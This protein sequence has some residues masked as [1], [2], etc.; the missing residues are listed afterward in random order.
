[1]PAV[2][3]F[4][5]YFVH[6]ASDPGRV[7]EIN[8]D[9]MLLNAE[10]GLC[11]LADGMGG[12]GLGDVASQRTVTEVER[13]VGRHLPAAATGGWSAWLGRWRNKGQRQADNGQLARQLYVLADIVREANR[14]LYLSNREHGAVDGTG[15]GTTLV[16]CRL[17]PGIAQ[18]Q[19]F[20]V[21]DSVCTAG[22]ARRCRP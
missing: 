12:H 15:S 2:R 22:A 17:L 10:I 13:L 19:I 7:R 6:G 9:A 1:M 11:L 3:I 8:E 5:R 18:M 21:G 20:H 14:A 4:N 16:G